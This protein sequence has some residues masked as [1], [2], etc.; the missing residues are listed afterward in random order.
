MVPSLTMAE[1]VRALPFICSSSDRPGRRRHCFPRR[2]SRHRRPVA[3]AFRLDLLLRAS[4]R[5]LTSPTFLPC[6]IRWF[7]TS[8]HPDGPCAR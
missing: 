4:V 5:R 6:L 8:L 7:V 1:K 3:C 2:F